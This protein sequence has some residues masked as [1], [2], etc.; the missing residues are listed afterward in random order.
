MKLMNEINLMA[1]RTEQAMTLIK[2]DI[3]EEILKIT[4][5]K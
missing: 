5:L 3:F 2:L 4:F 1:M